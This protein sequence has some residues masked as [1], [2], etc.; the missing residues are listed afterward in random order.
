MGYGGPNSQGHCIQISSASQ[1]LHSIEL[2]LELFGGEGGGGGGGG[3][4]SLK[5][6]Q[7][8]MI[9]VLWGSSCMLW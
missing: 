2:Q 4:N 8:A 9:S 1:I 6:N 5:V 3:G 7:K